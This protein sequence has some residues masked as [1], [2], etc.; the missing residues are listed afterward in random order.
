MRNENRT[1]VNTMLI[2]TKFGNIN[3]HHKDEQRGKNKENGP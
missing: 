1:K 2:G 3:G